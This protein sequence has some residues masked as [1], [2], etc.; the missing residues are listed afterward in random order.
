VTAFGRGPR[1]LDGLANAAAGR[2]QRERCSAVAAER[3]VGIIGR[4][5]GGTGD[6]ECA[7]APSTES[8]PRPVLHTARSADHPA[9]GTGQGLGLSAAHPDSQKKPPRTAPPGAIRKGLTLSESR[10]Q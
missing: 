9:K 5:A 4:P 10:V 3:F 8:P 6:G 1:G 7:P 2:T